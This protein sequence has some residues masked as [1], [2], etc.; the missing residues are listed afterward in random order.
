MKSGL[1]I[2]EFALEIERQQN[3]KRD[4]I[5]PTKALVMLTDGQLDKPGP[6][7]LGSDDGKLPAATINDVAHGQI[8]EYTKIPKPYYDRMLAE[9]PDLLSSNVERWF[10]KYPAPRLL[11]TLD[12]KLRAFLS[13]HYRNTGLENADIAEAAL[14]ALVAIGAEIMSCDITDK[15]LYIKAVD[16]RIKRDIPCGRK[17]GDGSHVF[18]HTVS[19]AVIILNSE[20]GLGAF[21]IDYGVFDDVCTNLAATARDGMRRTHVGGK[22]QA[23]DNFQAKLSDE[24]KAA[25]DRALWLEMRDTVKLAFDAAMFEAHCRKL[26]DMTEQPIEGDPVKVVELTVKKFG[27]TQENGTSILKHL[28]EG[29][30]LSR[31]GL[32]NAV[33]RTAQDVADYDKATDLEYA[34]GKLVE[35]PQSEWREL[36]IAA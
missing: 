27:F 29:G 35:L 5:V 13:D 21:H 16:P 34:G 7:S 22:L 36:A 19:P 12:G 15:R 8:A 31:F 18:F 6:M 30:D 9:A 26:R 1:S 24:T 28:I 14:P 33:T 32:Y 4:F 17:L 23:G 3:A 20:V 2:Q 25:K 11:R 10:Q